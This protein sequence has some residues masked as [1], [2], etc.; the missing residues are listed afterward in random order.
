MERFRIAWVSSHAYKNRPMTH[1]T[2]VV[3][4]WFAVGLLVSSSAFLAGADLILKEDFESGASRWEPTDPDAWKL[5]Q[6]RGGHV[7][8]LVTGRSKYNPPHRSP[9]GIALLRDVNVGDF[10]LTAKVKTTTDYYGHRSLCLFFGYQDPANFYYVHFG[11]EMDDHANQIFVVDDAP[12][13]KISTRTT[14]GTPWENDT[15]H[16]VKIVRTVADGRIDIFFDDLEHPIM[17]ATDKRF[18]WGRVGV[19][20]F[21]DTGMWDDIVLNGEKVEPLKKPADSGE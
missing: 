17:T 8:E 5:S 11:Q 3:A 19:G 21:D 12:R 6:G 15:W 13:T 4:R 7:L 20:S 1:R 14:A 2:L 9:L 16:R 10:T 18:F